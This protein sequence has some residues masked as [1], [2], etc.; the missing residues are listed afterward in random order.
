[1]KKQKFNYTMRDSG[2]LYFWLLIANI[3]FSLIFSVICLKAAQMQGIT[4]DE[5]FQKES[6]TYISMICTQVLYFGVF[7]LY[8]FIDRTD[9]VIA[10]K[11]KAKPNWIVVLISIAL[12]LLCLFGFNYFI[13]LF[14]HIIYKVFGV[15]AGTL[16]VSN[17]WWAFILCAIFVALIPAIVE[18]LIFRGVIFNGLKEKLSVTKAVLLSAIIFALM[19]MSISQ[20]VYQF[21]IGILFALV[22]HITGSTLYSIIIHFVNNFTV[23]VIS[24]IDANAFSVSKWG[25]WEIVG[26]ISLLLG[27][28]AL[29]IFI[30]KFLQKY[31]KAHNTQAKTIDRSQELEEKIQETQGLSEYEIRQLNPTKISDKSI[32]IISLILAVVLWGVSVFG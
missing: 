15:V 13:G 7:L 22:C 25:A 28:I 18:E 14:D 10:T 29:I 30:L 8:N 27:A 20:L 9:F 19:H 26:A 24:F 31:C 16:S 11:I 2:S 3:V 17:T 6:I 5:F 12:G 4:I 1:M 23:L 21:A 32:L